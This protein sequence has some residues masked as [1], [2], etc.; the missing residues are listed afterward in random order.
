[1]SN[2]MQF[3]QM[4]NRV[5]LFQDKTIHIKRVIHII[6]EKY[7]IV[8]HSGAELFVQK[9]DLLMKFKLQGAEVVAPKSIELVES[10]MNKMDSIQ[11]ILM[12]TIAKVQNDAGYAGQAK[13]INESVKSLIE[14]K[15]TQIEMVRVL[16]AS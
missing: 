14:L 3:N 6:D 13:Q 1:M 10:E 5:Y 7:R 15:K 16:K 9:D 4:I 8:D 11:D 12:D 2:P